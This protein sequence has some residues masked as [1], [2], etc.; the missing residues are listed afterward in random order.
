MRKT[1]LGGC[2][3]AK[4]AR[5]LAPWAC[6]VIK[7]CGGYMAFESNDDAYTWVQQRCNATRT[8]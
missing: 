5:K 2:K 6:R 7:V 8:E 1:F 4:T 3:S